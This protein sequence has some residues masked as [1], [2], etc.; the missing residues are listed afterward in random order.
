[1]H[2]QS[3][4]RYSPITRARHWNSREIPEAL[5]YTCAKRENKEREIR[6]RKTAGGKERKRAGGERRDRE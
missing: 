3:Q 1:M 5:A 4:K 6:E 2:S